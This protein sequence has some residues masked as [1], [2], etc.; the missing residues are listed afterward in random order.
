MLIRK[1]GMAATDNDKP[2][3]SGRHRW[4]LIISLLGSLP[5]A[6]DDG[7]FSPIIPMAG[8]GIACMLAG[9]ILGRISL[10]KKSAD[11]AQR[12]IEEQVEPLRLKNARLEESVN[13]LRQ[14]KDEQVH[15][16]SCCDDVIWQPS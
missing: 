14:L 2:I 6:A 9:F 1:N 4:L 5:L 11:M 7:S 15:T 10:Q 3:I 16:Q 13:D 8:V 12:I